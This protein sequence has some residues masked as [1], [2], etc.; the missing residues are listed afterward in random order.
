MLLVLGV[1]GL[2]GIQEDGVPDE[3]R[4]EQS[5]L[6]RVHAAD[7]TQQETAGLGVLDVLQLED[8]E[9]FEVDRLQSFVL[10]SHDPLQDRGIILGIGT[11]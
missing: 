2:K 3:E 4:V 1:G 7:P 11:N 9:E 10:E 8:P 5:E 6:T